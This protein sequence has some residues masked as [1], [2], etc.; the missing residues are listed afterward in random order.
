MA[1]WNILKVSMV[2]GLGLGVLGAPA[3][4]SFAAGEWQKEHP[5]RAEVNKRLR[6]QNRRIRNGVKDG[7]LTKE[8]A[9]E[10]RSD[11]RKIRQEERAMAR[12]NGGRLTKAEQRKLNRQETAVSRKIYQEKHDGQTS[13]SPQASSDQSEPA[14]KSEAQ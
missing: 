1:C 9:Q 8:E 13:A 6:N 12:Q 5:R 10:L 2:L 14:G 4:R 7:T 3:G 11:D